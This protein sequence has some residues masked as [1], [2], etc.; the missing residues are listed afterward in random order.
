MTET[1]ITRFSGKIFLAGLGVL[2]LLSTSGLFAQVTNRSLQDSI[3]F[4]CEPCNLPCDTIQHAS[5]GICEVCGMQ[6][7]AT[8]AG[9]KPKQGPI[10]KT[11]GKT[12]AVLLFPGVEVIDFAGPY[13]VFEAAGAR[14]FTV[15]ETTGILKAGKALQVKPD[16]SFADMPGA[17]IILVPGGNVDR[18]DPKILNWLKA[19]DKQAEK[20]VSVCNGA[21]FLAGAGL[22]DGLSATTTFPLVAALQSISPKTKVVN[23]QRYVNNGHIITSAGLSAG[24]DAALFV[25]SEYIG[26]VGAQQIAMTLEYNWNDGNGYVRGQLADKHLARSMDIFSPFAPKLRTYAGDR[27]QWQAGLDIETPLSDGQLTGLIDAQFDQVNQWKRA[28]STPASSRWTF[29][30]GAEDWNVL[31]TIEAK[32]GNIRYVTLKVWR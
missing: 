10:S 7:F 12:V 30:N 24:I 1:I 32:T 16:Y 5:P 3:V 19:Q 15:A 9:L 29:K 28:G 13:E 22:L 25:V 17:D 20:I 11:F 21:F 2:F 8:Y 27:N 23:D 14:V 6:L 4:V 26:V 18:S 31:A